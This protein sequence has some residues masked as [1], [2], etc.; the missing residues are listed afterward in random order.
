MIAFKAGCLCYRERVFSRIASALLLFLL[1]APAWAAPLKTLAEIRALSADQAAMNLP[2]EVEGTVIYF[3]RNVKNIGDAEG[4]ILHDGTAG[5]YI[6]SPAPFGERDRIRP[7]TRIRVKGHTN[8]N[9]YFPNIGNAA[10]EILGQGELPA[11]HRISGREL[12]SRSIDSEWVEIEAVVVGVEPGGL[13]FTLVVEIDDR[14]FKAEVP[15]MQ[16]AQ[17]RAAGLMQQRVRLQGV[18]GTIYNSALQLTGRYFFVPSFDHF[19]PEK[20]ADHG[21]IVP[22]RTIGSLLT[23]DHGIEEMVRV[24]GVVTQTARGGF[25][26]RDPTGSTYV[27]AAEDSGYPVGSLVE[28]EGFAAVTPFR[29]ILRAAKIVCLGE[30]ALDAPAR[31]KPAN[32]VNINLHDERVVVDCVFLAV[33]LG[34]EETVLQCQDGDCYFEAWLPGSDRHDRSLRPGDKLRLTG[35]YEVTTTRPM[36]RIEWANGFRLN[37]TGDS[38]IEILATAPWWSPER[39]FLA[40]S[41]ALAALCIVFIWGWQL[42]RRVAAQS[43]IISSQIEQATIKD[44]RERI[45][46]ELHDTLEQDLTGLSMQL[47]NLAPAL[48]GDRELARQ[49]LSLA[50]GMLQHCRTE[51]R[52]SVSDLR[53]P[54]LIMRALPEAVRE[55]LPAA[56]AGCEARI[57][58][59]LQ[60]TPQPLRAT[61]QNHL[62]RIARE[63][64]FNAARHANPTTIEVRLAYDSVGVALE[65]IDD[66]AGFAAS[67]KPPAE[68]FGLVG[69]RERANKIQA[70]LSIN[71]MLGAGTAVRVQLPW[72]SPVA[73]PAPDHDTQPRNPDSHCGRSRDGPP[74]ALRGDRS[75][76]R[77]PARRRGRKW[78]QGSRTLP[79][80]TPGR[81]HY[82]LP[83]SRPRR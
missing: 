63:A 53:N 44:E 29:P 28:V 39:V 46:R 64:V 54:H 6:S 69:M 12:F 22:L 68:H 55:S 18:V 3:D 1:A 8:P 49:R 38:A 7:G 48:D 25:Y 32:G 73:H 71:S 37:L 76:W 14:I 61:T 47:G 72:S 78:H 51:A 20:R 79:H 11:P 82:G 67:E 23:S 66:G 41:L 27:Q 19:I 2:V 65:I 50:R 5:C 4:L 24:H 58:F 9:S 33:R 34:R 21:G 26:L 52:A 62:L 42:R 70:Q 60:G 80:L 59:D 36:P 10:V 77:S 30:T 75:N 40:L 13:A 17:Q 45:A 81:R 74:R 56:A 31:L 57:A 43:A 35:I 15:Q 83:A 16:D